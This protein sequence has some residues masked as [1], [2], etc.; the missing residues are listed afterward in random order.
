MQGS[1]AFMEGADKLKNE[2]DKLNNQLKEFS[3]PFYSPRYAGHMCFETSMP[4]ILGWMTT[5]RRPATFPFCYT[6][7]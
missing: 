3:I 6:Q 5:V 4:A 1:P 2:L 7:A